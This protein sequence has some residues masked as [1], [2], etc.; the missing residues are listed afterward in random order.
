MSCVSFDETIQQMHFKHDKNNVGGSL[1]N[2]V[3]NVLKFGKP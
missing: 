1:R 2:S 3:R